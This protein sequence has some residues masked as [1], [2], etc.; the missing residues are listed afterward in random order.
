MEP[1]VSGDYGGPR[2]RLDLKYQD[3][4]VESLRNKEVKIGKYQ[5]LAEQAR[6]E[7]KG[8]YET[9]MKQRDEGLGLSLQKTVLRQDPEKSFNHTSECL[10]TSHHSI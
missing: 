8:H 5:A 2:T 6:V 7:A 1:L 9:W 4:T 10:N 3:T